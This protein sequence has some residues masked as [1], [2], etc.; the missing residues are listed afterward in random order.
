MAARCIG[1]SPEQII[2]QFE[3]ADYLAQITRQNIFAAMTGHGKGSPLPF[4][5]RMKYHVVAA[6]PAIDIELKARIMLAQDALELVMFLRLGHRPALSAP[7]QKRICVI[8]ILRQ[9]LQR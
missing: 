5:V 9:R 3:P 6:L 1:N 8:R 7:V 2:R 4:D